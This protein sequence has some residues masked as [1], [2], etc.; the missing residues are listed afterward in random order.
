MPAAPSW[1]TGTGPPPWCMVPSY[2]E[3]FGLVALEAQ[4]C[5]TPV[6]AAVGGRAAHRGPG[7]RVRDARGRARPGQ[8]RPGAARAVRLAPAWLA[9]LSR[10][11]VAHASR[12]GWG[13]DGGPAAHGLRRGDEH[14]S[15]PGQLTLRRA[16]EDAVA[17]SGSRRLARG[18]PEARRRLEAA[19]RD[20][21]G[22]GRSRAGRRAPA[23]GSY[24]V[25][26]EGQHKLAT[27]TWLI[28]GAHSLQRGGVLLPPAGRGPRPLL[29]R[30][31][32]ERNGRMYGV[33]F[34]VD[35]NGDVYLVGRLPCC[36]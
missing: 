4:A 5:G 3:S 31:P 1:P 14:L 13:R 8:L 9:W 33:H 35:S 12:F 19:Q 17:M 26:L 28:V 24:L 2:S 16:D 30:F 29:L 25:K 21:V 6:I 22:A 7:R 36:R 23:A 32:L 20:R 15:G 18:E 27:M 11:A 10:G 34:A